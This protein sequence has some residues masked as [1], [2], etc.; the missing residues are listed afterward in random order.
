MRD[1]F[2]GVFGGAGE[3]EGLGPVEGRAEPDFADFF[4]VDLCGKEGR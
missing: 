2:A 4:A 3:L 1:R